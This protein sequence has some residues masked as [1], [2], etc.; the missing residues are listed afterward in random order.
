MKTKV[1]EYISRIQDGGAETLVKDYALLLDKDK[2]DVTVLCEDIKKNSANYKIL[3]ENNVKL[4]STYGS[5]DIICRILA[6]IFG[7]KFVSILFSK[8]IKIIK[9]DVIHTHLESLEVLYHSR[10][11]L[12]GINLLFTCHNVPELKIGDKRPKERDACKYLL[13]YNN[14]QIIALHD[15]MAKEINE[16]FNINNVEVIKNGIDFNKYLNISKSKEEIRELLHINNDTFVL[17]SVG[18]LNYQKY[19]EFTINVFNEIKKINPNS[20]LLMVGNGPLEQTVNKL[21]QEHNLQDDV[22]LLSHRDD[23]PMLMKAMNTFIFPSRYEGLGIVLIEAQV[24]NIPC[25]VSENIPHEAFNSNLITVLNLNDDI[26]TWAKMCLNPK[27][28]YHKFGN[29]Q[30]YNMRTVIKKLEDLYNKGA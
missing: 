27:S 26:S 10:N 13:E 22:I 20:K 17:G 12:D 1:V 8:A 24:S 28:N 19:P 6:R 25:V 11:D 3:K 15:D 7:N 4:I 9:P 21:I 18:R 5:F 14:L 16:M 29:I 30:E 2:F 23:I